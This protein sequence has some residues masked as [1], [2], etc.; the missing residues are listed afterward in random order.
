[1]FH[2]WLLISG[3]DLGFSPF[4]RMQRCNRPAMRLYNG[5]HP[6]ALALRRKTLGREASLF[7]R[8]GRRFWHR[9]TQY[10]PAVC[11]GILWRRALC[12]SPAPRSGMLPIAAEPGVGYP[13]CVIEDGSSQN[14]RRVGD[15]VRQANWALIG[16]WPV[17]ENKR[18]G[19]FHVPGFLF[20]RRNLPQQHLPASARGSWNICG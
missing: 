2:P 14:R 13:L 18:R 16:L 7:F 9:H 1:M 20:V 12:Q 10:R 6:P 4:V 3:S 8:P 11:S 17:T 19:Q 15:D 5:S